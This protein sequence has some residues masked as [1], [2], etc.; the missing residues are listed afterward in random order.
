M[1]DIAEEG[2]AMHH[3]VYSAGYYKRDDCL[4]LSARDSEGNRLETIE[5]SLKT[6]QVVQSRGKCNQMT[7]QHNEILALLNR[8]MDMIRK[9]A[10]EAA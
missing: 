8:N 3:C 7:P 10:V 5:V 2:K 1:Q 9:A 4:I 6:F